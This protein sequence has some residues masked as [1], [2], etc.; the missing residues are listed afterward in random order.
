MSVSGP[1]WVAKFPPSTK[2]EDLVE[3]FRANVQRFL[4]ALKAA[5]ASVEI[6][7]TLR[8]PER[9]FLMHYSFR[10]A[11]SGDDPA[12]IPPMAG[13]DIQW[14]HKTLTGAPD[15]A[16]SKAAAE[17]MVV[18]YDIAFEPSLTSRHFVGKAIDMSIR[19][20]NTLV[21][22]TA[23]GVTTAIT[24]SPKDGA[25]NPD[26]HK[27]GLSYGV[28]KLVSDRPHWSVDGH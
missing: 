12:Q 1:D 17:Q 13:L 15:P 6:A 21:I 2:V 5:G 23:A 19:W 26:L 7:D 20:L 3:P 11:R 10:I 9:G 28:I 16:N 22:Q 27:V 18:G 24:S 14:L 8:R 25:V 4:A